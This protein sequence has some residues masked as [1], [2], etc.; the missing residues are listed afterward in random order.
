MQ[1]RF[2]LICLMLSTLNVEEGSSSLIA[3][4]LLSESIVT[5]KYGLH[6]ILSTVSVAPWSKNAVI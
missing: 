4:S 3:Q 1:K 2:E 5:H 6:D